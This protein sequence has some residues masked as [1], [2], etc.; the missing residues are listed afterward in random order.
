M[1]KSI[2]SKK[3]QDSKLKILNFFWEKDF[4]WEEYGQIDKRK[5]GEKWKAGFR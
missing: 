3:F 5:K 1:Y 4:L 2:V